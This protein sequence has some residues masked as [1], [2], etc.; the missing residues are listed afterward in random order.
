MVNHKLRTPLIHL[1][2]LD[3]LAQSA[4][5]LS[6]D[7]ITE[8]MSIAMEGARR[9]QGAIDAVLGYMSAPSLVPP[10]AGLPLDQ[11]SVLVQAIGAAV[12]VDTIAVACQ[13]RLTSARL[14]LARQTIELVLTELL[15]NAENSI[16]ST[17][18]VSRCWCSRGLRR[19]SAFRCVMIA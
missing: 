1:L 3:L 17:R 7:D 16:R 10:E 2:S 13:D 9:L 8:I 14:P 15:E 11:L 19:G 5:V 18:R 12:G 4:A 6:L